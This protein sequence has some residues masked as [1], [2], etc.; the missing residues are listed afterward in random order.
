[1]KS[2]RTQLIVAMLV[3]WNLAWHLVCLPLP[4]GVWACTPAAGRL[5]IDSGAHIT[6][7]RNRTAAASNAAWAL[8]LVG[9]WARST[10]QQGLQSKN[11]AALRRHMLA[12]WSCWAKQV[13]CCY[14]HILCGL[15][16]WATHPG[17]RRRAVLGGRTRHGAM[18]A[19][20]TL[21]LFSVYRFTLKNLLKS[22]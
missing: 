16:V 4:V 6:G 18:C 14:S 1:M 3:R 20:N 12:S 9:V 13:L 22:N 5:A 11:M 10:M 19:F 21:R 8:S 15:S 2:S 17:R 7:R